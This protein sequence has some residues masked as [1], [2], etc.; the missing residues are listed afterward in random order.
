MAD[1]G[2]EVIELPLELVVLESARELLGQ[3]SA[4]KESA[5]QYGP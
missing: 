1:D 4:Q 5:S 2:G 3:H